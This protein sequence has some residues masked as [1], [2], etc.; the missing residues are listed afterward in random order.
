MQVQIVAHRL[1]GLTCGEHGNVH[2]AIQRGK[3]AVYPVPCDID[4]ATWTFECEAVEAGG[5]IDFRGPYAQGKRGDRFVYLSWGTVEG[6]GGFSMFGR[7]KLMLAAVPADA[8]P[9]ALEPGKRLVG[10][11]D[12]VDDRGR[13]RYASVRPPAI[14]WSVED[15]TAWEAATT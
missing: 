12:L 4:V 2:I 11:L 8:L 15:A 13:M 6:E 1:P 5:S 9:A 7:I 14:Q 10:V 3:E